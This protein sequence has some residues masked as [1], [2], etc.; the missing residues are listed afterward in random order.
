MADNSLHADPDDRAVPAPAG[1][2]GLLRRLFGWR[3]KAGG[4]AAMAVAPEE[5]AIAIDGDD[6]GDADLIQSITGGDGDDM[7][8]PPMPVRREGFKHK[9]TRYLGYVFWPP[10]LRGDLGT[11]NRRLLLAA[12][13]GVL[14]LLAGAGG[15]LVTTGQSLPFLPGSEVVVGVTRLTLPPEAKLAPEQKAGPGTAPVTAGRLASG[16]LIAPDP[17][18]S[19]QTPRG[20]VPKIGAD[21]RQPWNAYARPYTEPADRPRIAVV[22]NDLGLNSQL[23]LLAAERL[24]PEISF[25]FNPYALNLADQIERARTAGHE[26]LLSLPM[27]PFDYPSSDP[28]P[29]TLLTSLNEDENVRRLDWALARAPGY[30][31]FVNLLGGKYTAS[32]D[33]M[34]FVAATLK[35]RGLMFLDARTAPKSVAA[36]VVREAGGVYAYSNRQIDQQPTAE[37]IDARLEELE[38]TVRVSGVAVGTAQPYPVTLDRLLA[39]AGTLKAKN[40][41]LAPVSAVVN[42]QAAD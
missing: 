32:P 7:A 18:L 40:I 42:R 26:V 30:I 28:G 27:E 13:T 21:G 37:L 38:R 1:R 35:Q 12:W 2:G 14:L 31:G 20:I 23:T 19:E 11:V 15:W 17:A 4:A 34:R 8:P 29:Y 39:W 24:P 6:G 9:L 22:L 41:A 3:R 36:R 5:P 16:L 10:F 25:A 33:H